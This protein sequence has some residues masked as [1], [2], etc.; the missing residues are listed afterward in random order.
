VSETLASIK[1]SGVQSAVGL[2]R[3]M[4]GYGMQLD[5]HSECT[6]VRRSN[7]QARPGLGSAA[8]FSLPFSLVQVAR[9]EQVRDPMIGFEID[10]RG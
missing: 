3:V 10:C 5:D 6:E 1:R 9:H 4:G 7:Y 2:I 8:V